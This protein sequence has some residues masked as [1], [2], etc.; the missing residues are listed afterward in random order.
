MVEWRAKPLIWKLSVGYCHEQWM[1][2]SHSK[3]RDVCASAILDSKYEKVP[4]S[5]RIDNASVAFANLIKMVQAI[6]LCDTRGTRIGTECMEAFHEKFLKRSSE[7]VELLLSRRGQK[8]CGN[9]LV[10]SETQFFQ[11]DIERLDALLVCL[12]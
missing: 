2:R 3:W 5:N 12:G 4:V 6:E 9:S 10:Q 11:H 7:Y 1:S 8:N